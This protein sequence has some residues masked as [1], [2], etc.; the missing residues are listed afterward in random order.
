MR[1]RR[2]VFER[3]ENEEALFSERRLIT[4]GPGDFRGVPY[5]DF[6]LAHYTC[7]L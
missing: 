3:R 2:P 5:P 6:S 7:P 4:R 1:T